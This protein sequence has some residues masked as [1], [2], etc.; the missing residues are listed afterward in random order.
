[1]SELQKLKEDNLQLRNIIQQVLKQLGLRM[2][3]FYE[4]GYGEED[5]KNKELEKEIA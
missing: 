4:L 5:Y 2:Q 1:V 3:D